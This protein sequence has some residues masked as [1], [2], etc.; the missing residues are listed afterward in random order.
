[1][2]YFKRFSVAI[3]LSIGVAFPASAVS[4][5]FNVEV[6]ESSLVLPSDPFPPLAELPALGTLGLR[7]VLFLELTSTSHETR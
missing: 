3:F 4:V 1:M 2:H 6:T 5:T 7:T